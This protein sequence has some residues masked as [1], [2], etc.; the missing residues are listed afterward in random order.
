MFD[1][2]G[3]TRAEAKRHEKERTVDVTLTFRG[4]DPA[5]TV[6]GRRGW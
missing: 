3:A 1:N 5:Q 2:L 4:A 6:K